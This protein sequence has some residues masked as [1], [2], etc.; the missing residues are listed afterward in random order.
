MKFNYIQYLWSS[1]T[2][3]E[4]I[5]IINGKGLDADRLR[6]KQELDKREQEQVEFIEL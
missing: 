2:D 4:L 5:N 6:A 1:Y 3:A